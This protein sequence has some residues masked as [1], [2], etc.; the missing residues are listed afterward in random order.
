MVLRIFYFGNGVK[1][2]RTPNFE[3]W[4]FPGLALYGVILSHDA[5]E[6]QRATAPS[7]PCDHRV[8]LLTLHSVFVVLDDLLQ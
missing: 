6:Q 8:K 1:M 5:G 2:I 7:Q 4:Y 3:F